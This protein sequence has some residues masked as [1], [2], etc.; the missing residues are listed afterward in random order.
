MNDAE[1]ASPLTIWLDRGIVF[2]LFVFAAFAPHSIAV[3]QSAWLLGMLFWLVRFFIYPRPK[4]YRTPVDYALLGFFILTGVAAVLSYEPMVS[5]GKLRAASLFTI[6]YLFAENVPSRRVVRLLALTLVASC[7]INVL[8][9]AGTRVIGQGV[10]LQAVQPGSPLSAGVLRTP[11]RTEP[12]AIISG[13]TVL[14]VDGRPLHNAEELAAGIEPAQGSRVAVL[15]IYRDAEYPPLQV[16]RGR[17]LPGVSAEER[18][19][20]GSWSK[21]R[22]W[23]A[24]GFYGH[25]VTY[26]EAL[27]LIASLALGLFIC[28]PSRRSVMGGLLLLALAGL[29]FALLLTVTR[30]SWLAFLVSAGLM[31]VVGTSRKTI[32]V[33][34]AC[35]IPLVLGGLLLLQQKRHV[36]FFDQ[37]DDSTTWRQTVWHEGFDLLI[38]KPRHLLVGV[39]MDSLKAHWRQWGLFDQGRLPVGHMHSNLLQIALERGLPAL[40]VWFILL[41]VYA[42]AL[43]QTLRALSR[44][45]ADYGGAGAKQSEQETATSG[46]TVLGPW[47]DRGIVLGALGGLAGFFTSGLVHYNWG[48]SEVVMI[49]YFIMGLSLVVARHTER[50]GRD[51]V[52]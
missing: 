47:I 12:F 50:S 14:S 11:A 52:P 22:D 32:L 15:R 1:N 17:L 27:Q 2:W 26:A 4:I 21:G 34:A 31:I 41:G 43:V 24:S 5:I 37:K 20:I 33:A 38:S 29:G 49:F 8:Y 44:G 30:A 48:D 16:P 39:G 35:A 19:G 23:R 45:K 40:T 46:S 6:V 9:T 28:L 3:T 36:G 42:R 7:L 13:D 18:L 10:K 51:H 25:Y